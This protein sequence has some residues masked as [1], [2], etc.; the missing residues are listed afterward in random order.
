MR[1]KQIKIALTVEVA[2]KVAEEMTRKGYKIIAM[3]PFTYKKIDESDELMM[4]IGVAIEY[5]YNEFIRNYHK[6]L[7]KVVR[8]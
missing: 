5:E 6:E 8:R 2:N 3:R 4:G 7:K 1:Y